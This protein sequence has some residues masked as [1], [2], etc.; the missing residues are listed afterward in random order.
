[1][2][3]FIGVLN[4]C[5]LS[6]ILVSVSQRWYTLNWS[7]LSN[8]SRSGTSLVPSSRVLRNSTWNS[9]ISGKFPNSTSS[10]RKRAFEQN[11]NKFFSFYNVFCNISQYFYRGNIQNITRWISLFQVH[12]THLFTLQ[13]SPSLS[14]YPPLLSS[15]TA[16]LHMIM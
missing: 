9:T 3:D 5:W 4:A 11:Q 6:Y 1:M 15:Y 13:T 2:K 14:H 10:W 7:T 16:T 8:F 12:V